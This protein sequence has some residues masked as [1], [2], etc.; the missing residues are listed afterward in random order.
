MAMLGDLG[1]AG[2][3]GFGAAPETRE[4]RVF[5]AGGNVVYTQRT[6]DTAKAADSHLSA[7]G[8]VRTGEWMDGSAPVKRRGW[9][10][11]SW[12]G[13]LGAGI[14]VVLFAGCQSMLNSGDER[15]DT[16]TEYDANYYCKEFVKDRLKAPST[17]E[18]SG[19]TA[20]GGGSSWTSSG[21]VESENGFGGMTQ[22]RYTCQLT[23]SSG[24]ESWRGE[25]TFD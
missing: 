7:A 15:S 22:T 10:S 25:V 2:N 4:I 18:F 9:L 21:V 24:D 14:V 6:L 16:P 19:E 3:D 11:R 20:F 1:A 8:Y 5:D 12:P 23:Y 13:L 17:A